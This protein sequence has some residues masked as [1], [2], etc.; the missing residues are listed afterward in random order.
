MGWCQRY[1]LY[2]IK[3][4]F[5]SRERLK[6]LLIMVFGVAYRMINPVP[7]VGNKVRTLG[8]GVLLLKKIKEKMIIMKPIRLR[9]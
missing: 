5:T 6:A 7:R 4:I 9:L 3:P 1:A 8:N 2:D